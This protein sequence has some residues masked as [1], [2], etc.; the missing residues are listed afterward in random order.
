MLR[1]AA[2]VVLRVHHLAVGFDVEDAA[3]TRNE[4]GLDAKLLLYVGRQ[5][6][7]P[8]RVV[9]D[10]AIGDADLHGCKVR[11]ATTCDQGGPVDPPRGSP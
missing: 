8:R 2:L 4:L 5:T 9:S 6:G 1:E 3:A 10:L 11:H 7:G